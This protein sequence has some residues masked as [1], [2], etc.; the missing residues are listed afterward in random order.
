MSGGRPRMTWHRRVEKELKGQGEIW[1]D[2]KALAMDMIG[3]FSWT[4]R[5]PQGIN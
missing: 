4:S 5:V 1:M 3:E 2:T